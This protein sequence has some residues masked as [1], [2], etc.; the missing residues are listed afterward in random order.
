MQRNGIKLIGRL[1]ATLKDKDGNIKQQFEKQNL[2]VNGGLD[3]FM[4]QVLNSPSIAVPSHM[5]IGTDGTQP[6]LSDNDLGSQ[7]GGR[8]S[9]S[10][11]RNLNEVE[12]SA[13]FGPNEPVNSEIEI[14][15]A[16]LFNAATGGTLWARITFG[17]VTKAPDDTFDLSWTWVLNN[18]N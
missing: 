7:Q 10:K 16:G 6:Q 12:F 4:E 3:G 2:I 11:Q 9:I 15:E 13:V 14:R 8:Q 17:V 18:A 5:G 1:K